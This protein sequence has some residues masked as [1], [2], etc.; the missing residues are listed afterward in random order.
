MRR[1]CLL[2]GRRIQK[3][4]IPKQSQ[5]TYVAATSQP[6]SKMRRRIGKT[7]DSS[8]WPSTLAAGHRQT[9]RLK[10][11]RRY[12]A[13]HDLRTSLAIAQ[14]SPHDAVDDELTVRQPTEDGVDKRRCNETSTVLARSPAIMAMLPF[15]PPSQANHA[16]TTHSLVAHSTSAVTPVPRTLGYSRSCPRLA[17]ATKVGFGALSQ[18]LGSRQVSDAG[19]PDSASMLPQLLSVAQD[20]V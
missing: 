9:K 6:L 18:R 3:S 8:S 19:F 1:D 10:P 16:L 11:Q 17:A 15:I 13:P 4:K 12:T 14:Q 2:V 7:C 5:N 20:G